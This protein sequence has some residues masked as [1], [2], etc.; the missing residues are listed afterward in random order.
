VILRLMIPNRHFCPA[1]NTPEPELPV[2]AKSE[3]TVENFSA[4]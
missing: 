2:V 4:R 1:S 3:R